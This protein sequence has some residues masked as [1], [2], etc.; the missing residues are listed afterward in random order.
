M[1]HQ[2]A[3]R[4]ARSLLRLLPTD[5][6]VETVLSECELSHEALAGDGEIGVDAYSRLFIT[7]IIHL[8]PA[9][10][11]DDADHITQFSSY[12]LIINAMIQAPNLGQ[13]IVAGD[14][15]MRR[16]LPE[17]ES[18]VL[19][20]R[21]ESASLQFHLPDIGGDGA[22]STDMFT[23]TQFHWQQG[24]HGHA[25]SL[26]LW[27]RIACWLIGD[28]IELQ[29]VAVV[30]QKP[31]EPNRIASL[32]ECPLHFGEHSCSL[33]FSARHLDAPINRSSEQVLDMLTNFPGDLFK[34]DQRSGSYVERIAAMIG[35]D[36]SGPIPRVG[37]IAKR[38]NMSV[39][40]LHR[41]LQKE[42]TSYQKIKHDCRYQTAVSYLRQDIHTVDEIAGLLGYSDTSTF[43]R[44]FKKWAGMTPVEFLAKNQ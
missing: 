5:A 29:S 15:L 36:F 8:Q 44:A 43:Y 11:G 27:H 4:Y 40:T 20:R 34:V 3:K 10:H 30:D 9:L 13:A 1:T 39:P 26:W 23:A 12:R 17:G 18:F 7:I 22:W 24:F 16:L 41:H 21:G 42:N 32:F 6:D 31:T 33:T 25:I 14:A 28:Y 35:R 38:M 19:E 37:E 2:L